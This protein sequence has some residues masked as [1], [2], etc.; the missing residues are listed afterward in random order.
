MNPRPSRAPAGHRAG[1]AAEARRRLTA[2]FLRAG[3]PSS[4]VPSGCGEAPARGSSAGAGP[5]RPPLPPSA[6]AA[7]SG[8]S[9][10]GPA[11]LLQRAPA[12]ALPE[13]GRSGFQRSGSAFPGRCGV[14][15]A[16]LPFSAV[17]SAAPHT[18]LPEQVSQC[19]RLDFFA[20]LRRLRFPSQAVGLGLQPKLGQ[21]Q[22]LSA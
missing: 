2:A 9:A 10:G 22:P 14:H 11:G 18:L 20:C 1:E 4:A 17:G 6:G 21:P 12:L 7:V 16:A 19:A 3:L 5:S 15:V 8:E 13:E